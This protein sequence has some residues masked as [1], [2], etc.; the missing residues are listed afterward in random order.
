MTTWGRRKDTN[1]PYIKTGKKGIKSSTTSPVAD[2]HLVES[3]LKRDV[4]SMGLVRSGHIYN[5]D[6]IDYGKTILQKMETIFQKKYPDHSIT[7]ELESQH[8]NV[9]EGVLEVLGRDADKI[10][11]FIDFRLSDENNI[12]NP[13]WV[14]AVPLYGS[15]NEADFIT[16]D[17]LSGMFQ[18]DGYKNKLRITKVDPKKFLYEWVPQK[19]PN[20][21]TEG[22]NRQVIERIKQSLRDKKPVETPFIDLDVKT[23]QVDAHE[24]RHRANA[25][26]ELGIQEI[27]VWVVSRI[28]IYAMSEKEK[29]TFFSDNY[30]RQ[31]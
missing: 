3:R 27:P 21:P 8:E 10:E 15:K 25:A 26:I 7:E 2:V 9:R 19:H 28:P 30:I 20:D 13:K 1:Q 12:E 5:L 4:D 16:E 18:T 22:Y 17:S 14:M 6:D 11:Q 23:G 31:S 29:E 24:G